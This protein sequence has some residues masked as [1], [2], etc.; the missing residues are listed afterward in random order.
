MVSYVA[1]VITGVMRYNQLPSFVSLIDSYIA[2]MLIMVHHGIRLI[3]F[4]PMAV[5]LLFVTSLGTLMM[6][7]VSTAN[8][9][10][11]VTPMREYVSISMQTPVWG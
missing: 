11:H 5:A 10:H 7:R 2:V 4:V 3:G 9:I 6:A 1:R 8:D